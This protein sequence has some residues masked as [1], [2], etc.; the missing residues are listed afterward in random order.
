[1]EVPKAHFALK[2]LLV[3]RLEAAEARPDVFNAAVTDLPVGD[4]DAIVA[5]DNVVDGI[6][7]VETSMGSGTGFLFAM[8]D[9]VYC[10]TNHHVL[11]SAQGLEILTADGRGFTPLRYEVAED[12]DLARILLKETP[13][14][15]QELGTAKLNTNIR[16]L[17]N[18][19]GAEV[20]TFDEG[21]VIGHGP[22]EVE[23]DADFIEGNSG[24]PVLNEADEIVGVATY[25]TSAD[26]GEENWVTKETRF[27][28][29]RRF[30]IRLT[31]SVV[32]V[33]IDA[34]R[35]KQGELIVNNHSEFIQHAVD[36]VLKLATSRQHRCHMQV[37][38]VRVCV[39]GCAKRMSLI[40]RWLVL[41]KICQRDQSGRMRF[42]LCN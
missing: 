42:K 25:I 13:A 26:A 5:L 8:N 22:D 30:A 10:V 9:R 36:L 35:L 4:A 27:A 18:S 39:V 17:G 19:G 15:F 14:C 28:K 16:I 32:W 31:D 24:S 3:E 40:W 21:K 20:V 38:R 41:L 37:C 29:A 6:C 23:V 34:N 1:L 11:G 33:P 2:H 7:V 12:R